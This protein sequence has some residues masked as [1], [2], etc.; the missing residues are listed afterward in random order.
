[1]NY[2]NCQ[3]SP[4]RSGRFETLN[5]ES[6]ELIQRKI[7]IG[8]TAGKPSSS[9][10]RIGTR[11]SLCSLIKELESAKEGR[12]CVGMH[13]RVCVCVVVESGIRDAKDVSHVMKLWLRYYGNV[14]DNDERR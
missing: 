3:T 2:F 7:V 1:M 6:E 14:N 12:G 11:S 5:T 13:C 10:S 4:S 8:K 9:P